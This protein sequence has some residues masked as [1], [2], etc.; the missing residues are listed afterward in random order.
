M[1]EMV[2]LFQMFANL[3]GSM[4]RVALVGLPLSGRLYGIIALKW[5]MCIRVLPHLLLLL[6]VCFFVYSQSVSGSCGSP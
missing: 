2:L 3:A 4:L 1:W 5:I 6:P